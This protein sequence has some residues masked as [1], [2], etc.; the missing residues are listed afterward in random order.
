MRDTVN[1]IYNFFV[2]NLT[3]KLFMMMMINRIGDNI[4]FDLLPSYFSYFNEITPVT[5][6][7]TGEIDT[8]KTNKTIK[9][10]YKEMLWGFLII[11]L[12][13]SFADMFKLTVV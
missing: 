9:K 13:I 4:I 7:S 6:T 12:I 1:K 10:I 3:L 2:K 8:D 11:V 5:Y